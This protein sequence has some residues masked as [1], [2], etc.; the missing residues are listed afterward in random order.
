M[1]SDLLIDNLFKMLGVAALTFFVGGAILRWLTRP[2]VSKPDHE[3]T[4]PTFYG[5][6]PASRAW[7]REQMEI[8][9]DIA[10]LARDPHGPA[11]AAA[12]D[13][14]DLTDAQRIEAT[15]AYFRALAA[16]TPPVSPSLQEWMDRVGAPWPDD[17]SGPDY[18]RKP[19]KGP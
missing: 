13:A 17:A 11:L 14:L 16:A 2:P 1:N 3:A 10:G 19:E 18:S 4:T 8:S 15:T 12:L 9:N 6:D 5:A 7:R